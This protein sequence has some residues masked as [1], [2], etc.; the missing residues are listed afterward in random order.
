MRGKCKAMASIWSVWL[1]KCRYL[2][3][4]DR[5]AKIK[6][7]CTRLNANAKCKWHHLPFSTSIVDRTSYI[8]HSNI[9]LTDWPIETSQQT[10]SFQTKINFTHTHTHTATL[11]TTYIDS[12]CPIATQKLENNKC[13]YNVSKNCTSSNNNNYNNNNFNNNNNNKNKGK[14]KGK[15]KDKQIEVEIDNQVSA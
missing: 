3:V 8:V 4:G 13:K 11:P 15:G 14:E 2:N 10:D 5:S 1:L 9:R 6:R 12:H 7:E